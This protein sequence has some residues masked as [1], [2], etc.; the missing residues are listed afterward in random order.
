[1]NEQLNR[2]SCYIRSASQ[3]MNRCGSSRGGG[4]A[5]EVEL[6]RRLLAGVDFLGA[7]VVDFNLRSANTIKKNGEEGDAKYVWR[8][9]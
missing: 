9:K 7:I 8:E 1:M 5:C 3:E 4:S 6:E 2:D